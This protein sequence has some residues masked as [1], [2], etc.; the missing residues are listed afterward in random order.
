MVSRGSHWRL[1][2]LGTLLY[3]LH[4]DVGWLI[5]DGLNECEAQFQSYVSFLTFPNLLET[6]WSRGL[7]FKPLIVVIDL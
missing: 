2:T 5:E 3:T 4:D 7:F 6:T 1:K